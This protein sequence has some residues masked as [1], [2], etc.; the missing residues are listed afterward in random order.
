MSAAITYVIERVVFGVRTPVFRATEESGAPYFYFQRRRLPTGI[1]AKLW[2]WG[3]SIVVVVG[4]Y[5]F[6]REEHFNALAIIGI[7]LGLI[8]FLTLYPQQPLTFFKDP[9][10]TQ[11]AGSITC[12]NGLAL[13]KSYEWL[14]HDEFNQTIAHIEGTLPRWIVKHKDGKE[15][16]R[17]E[18]HLVGRRTTIRYGGENLSAQIITPIHWLSN[19]ESITFP[20]QVLSDTDINV[21]LMVL[22]LMKEDRWSNYRS[23]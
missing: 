5:W 12:L 20:K 9:A 16:F 4:F 1:K 15:W 18:N 19:R 17:F 11:I 8:L 10:L 22:S 3:V 14:V 7:L 23:G 2:L 13:A 21:L 6:S